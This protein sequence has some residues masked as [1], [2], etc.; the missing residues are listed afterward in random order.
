MN[1]PIPPK[2]P[3]HIQIPGETSGFSVCRTGPRVGEFLLWRAGRDRRA[4]DRGD[5][6]KKQVD[7]AL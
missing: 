6:E 4:R 5:P 3:L 2:I 7:L 1:P